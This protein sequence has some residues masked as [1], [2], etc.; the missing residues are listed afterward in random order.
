[1]FE[2]ALTAAARTRRSASESMR[3]MFG[4][5]RSAT[6]GR[7]GGNR[8][9]RAGAH[10]RRLVVQ[11]ERRDEVALLERL[12]N[13][14]GVEHALLVGVGQL[15]DERLDGRR[16]AT[17]SRTSAARTSRRSMLRRKAAGSRAWLRPRRRSTAR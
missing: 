9:E 16:S 5:Q 14:D 1:M 7:A 15:L 3:S 11:Q 17:S 13:V 2:S 12:E 4:S 10:P 6:S 8:L